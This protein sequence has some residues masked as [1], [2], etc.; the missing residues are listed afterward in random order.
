MIWLS[1]LN[2]ICCLNSPCHAILHRISFQELGHGHL[3]E[4]MILPTADVHLQRAAP[5]PDCHQ[6]PVRVASFSKWFLGRLS[7]WGHSLCPDSGQVPSP[8]SLSPVGRAVITPLNT[9]ALGRCPRP[10]HWYLESKP[11]QAEGNLSFSHYL[12]GGVGW[13]WEGP[14]CR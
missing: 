8:R 6:A 12:C 5:S 7:S 10:N 11:P 9:P 2:S 4:A 14:N 3:W 13:R 1:N